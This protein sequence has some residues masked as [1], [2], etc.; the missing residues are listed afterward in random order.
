M[1]GL[2][3]A[4]DS[5]S[6]LKTLVGRIKVLYRVGWTVSLH[7]VVGVVEVW[8]GPAGDTSAWR[9]VNSGG[10]HGARRNSL[11]GVGIFEE[12]TEPGFLSPL[13]SANRVNKRR[14]GKPRPCLMNSPSR[15][16]WLISSSVLRCLLS[17]SPAPCVSLK[18][19]VRR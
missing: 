12:S 11:L 4:H 15:I 2:Q 16:A 14:N 19:F 17:V 13:A 7:G 8:G 18:R 5:K 10:A 6:K 9:T 1:S 3:L